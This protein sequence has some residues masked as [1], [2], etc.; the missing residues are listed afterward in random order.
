MHSHKKTLTEK[1]EER[2]DGIDIITKDGIDI[3]TKGT[4]KRS[5]VVNLEN[6]NRIKKCIKKS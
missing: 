3:I 4:N 5:I 2:N 6:K 1:K